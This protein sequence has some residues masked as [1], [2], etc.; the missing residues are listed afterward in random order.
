MISKILVPT[1]GSETSNKSVKYAAGLAKQL[2]AKIT[3]LSV[4]D[5]NV[6]SF[7]AQTVSAVDSP[8]HIIEPIDHYLKQTAEAYLKEGE[9]ICTKKGIQSKKVIR[10]GHPVEEIVNEAVKSKVDLIVMGSQGRS[11][12]K[13]AILGSVTFGV[14]HQDIK[15]PVLV[16]RK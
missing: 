7:I 16:V 14:I 6:G 2:G 4:I 11:A 1:D 3:L 12:L 13:A 10:S 5:I 8:T 15:I 9:K